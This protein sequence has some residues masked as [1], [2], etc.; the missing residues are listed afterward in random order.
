MHG[1]AREEREATTLNGMLAVGGIRE[2]VVAARRNGLKTLILPAAVRHD[3]D[4]LPDYLRKGLTVHFVE[5][6]DEVAALCF[7][8]GS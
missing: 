5:H 6:Y 7:G 1:E 3:F 4:E 2:K 8:R